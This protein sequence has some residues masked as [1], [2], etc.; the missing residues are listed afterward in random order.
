MQRTIK[1]INARY[2]VQSMTKLDYI[3]H[4]HQCMLLLMHWPDKSGSRHFINIFFSAIASPI[5]SRFFT[6]TTAGLTILWFID[7]SI[8]HMAKCGLIL[9][10]FNLLNYFFL[11]LDTHTWL[12]RGDNNIYLGQGFSLYFSS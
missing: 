5:G 2:I 10:P 9:Y 12:L 7:W 3:N 8:L 4:F 11:L 6:T 1:K